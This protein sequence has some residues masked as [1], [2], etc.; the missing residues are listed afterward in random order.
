MKNL[1]ISWVLTAISLLVV[2]FLIPGFTVNGIGSALIAA[3]VI[4]LING[5]VGLLLKIVTFPLTVLTL[6]LFYLVLNALLIMMAA[7]LVD[8]FVV[9]GF[10]AAFFG[11]IVLSL[12]NSALQSFLREKK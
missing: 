11:S 6:G 12:V 1:L 5:T 10:L 4:G 9:S 3:L 2:S 7:K 8:G